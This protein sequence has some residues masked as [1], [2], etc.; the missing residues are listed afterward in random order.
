VL[1]GSYNREVITHASQKLK[2]EVSLR[3]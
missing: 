1:H 3:D 2:H